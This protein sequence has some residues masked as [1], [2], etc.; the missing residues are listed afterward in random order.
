[1]SP[2]QMGHWESAAASAG[3]AWGGWLTPPALAPEPLSAMASSA[4]DAV[5]PRETCKVLELVWQGGHSGLLS[6][7][8]RMHGQQDRGRHGI[9]KLASSQ[10][11]RQMAQRSSSC[12]AML[13]RCCGGLGAAGEAELLPL[14]GAAA[15]AVAPE[16]EES[17]GSLAVLGRSGR[18]A[19][20]PPEGNPPSSPP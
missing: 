14:T 5:L 16:K 19:Q 3:P 4:R 8:R 2:R 7:H 9:P 11:P 15:V 6:A 18:N 10:L 13:S 1:M 17:P 12:V 20:V